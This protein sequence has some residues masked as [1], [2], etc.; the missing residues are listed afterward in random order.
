M[1]RNGG[2]IVCTR[3]VDNRKARLRHRP[4]RGS[5]VELGA[6]QPYG[7]SGLVLYWFPLLASCKQGY[8]CLLRS[9]WPGSEA[10]S[11]SHL[12]RAARAADEQWFAGLGAQSI[13]L[14]IGS[15]RMAGIKLPEKK[16]IQI[17]DNHI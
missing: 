5:E 16:V 14:Q 2:R 8:H 6:A 7:S 17:R 3:S 15:C 1:T 11:G 4:N 10:S 9:T 13:N 12:S